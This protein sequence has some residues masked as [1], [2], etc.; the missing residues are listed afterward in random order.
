MIYDENDFSF[1][2]YPVYTPSSIEYS[3]LS[4]DFFVYV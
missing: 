2:Y 1:Y 3:F 4:F